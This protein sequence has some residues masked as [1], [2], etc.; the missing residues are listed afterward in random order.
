MTLPPPAPVKAGAPDQAH[1][2]HKPPGHGFTGGN[3]N[4]HGGTGWPE[5]A[6]QPE[7]PGKPRRSPWP[8]LLDLGLVLI[9]FGLIITPRFLMVIGAVILVVALVGWLR[10]ARADYSRLDD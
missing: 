5:E 1:N 9:L 3:G 2:G 4:G 10:A 6:P 7:Q 8:F